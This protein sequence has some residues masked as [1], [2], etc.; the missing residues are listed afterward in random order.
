MPAVVAM[1]ANMLRRVPAGVEQ[2]SRPPPVRFFLDRFKIRQLS[3]R[4]AD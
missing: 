3:A 2:P 4:S 1:T